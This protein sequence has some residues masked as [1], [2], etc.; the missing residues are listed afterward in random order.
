[1]IAKTQAMMRMTSRVHSTLLRPTV[2]ATRSA[3]MGIRVRAVVVGAVVAVAVAA[4]IAETI[5]AEIA[6]AALAK[7]AA[8]PLATSN[9][10]NGVMIA[11]NRRAKRRVQNLVPSRGLRFASPSPH[12]PRPEPPSPLRARCMAQCVANSRPVN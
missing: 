9:L 8:T 4:E 1:M 12:S 7:A 5:A 3:G 11:A 2:R 10:A 6:K